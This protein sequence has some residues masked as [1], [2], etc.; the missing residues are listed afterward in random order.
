MAKLDHR[1][2][3]P[4]AD[5]FNNPKWQ[6]GAAVRGIASGLVDGQIMLIF[7]DDGVSQALENF[8]RRAHGLALLG[9]ANRRDSHLLTLGQL[10]L[11]LHAATVH[12]HLP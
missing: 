4:G 12:S 8:I 5:R 3:V 6:A 7:V 11:R 10:P 9:H 2:F 1:V